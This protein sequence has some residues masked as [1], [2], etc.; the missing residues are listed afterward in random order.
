MHW[1]AIVV[2]CG[3]FADVVSKLPNRFLIELSSGSYLGL[4]HHVRKRDPQDPLY[5]LEA[6]FLGTSH[7]RHHN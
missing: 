3:D 6:K 7:E 1:E 5:I 2:K 4:E